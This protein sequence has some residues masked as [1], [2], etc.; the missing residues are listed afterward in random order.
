M[1]TYWIALVLA[2][3]LVF[4]CESAE[5]RCNTARVAAHDA[6]AAYVTVIDAAASATDSRRESAIAA[7]A[8]VRDAECTAAW[9]AYTDELGATDDAGAFRHGVV[10]FAV[11]AI[12]I[13]QAAAAERAH[14][15]T[16]ALQLSTSALRQETEGVASGAIPSA[17]VDART[18]RIA[19]AVAAYHAAVDDAEA[20][21]TRTVELRRTAHAALNAATGSAIAARDAARAVPDDI[22]H[23]QRAHAHDL[24]GASWEACQR[25]DP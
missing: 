18:A 16:C 13:T 4:G 20:A 10:G 2:Q 12:A 24:A 1:R 6:W 5:E 19:S 14:S 7:A 3:V 23:A 22:E 25:V 15:S 17:L 9:M 21:A 11:A 8:P